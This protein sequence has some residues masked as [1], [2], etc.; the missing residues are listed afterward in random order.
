[1][2]DTEPTRVRAS[3]VRIGDEI[4]LG[5]T[6]D[7]RGIVAEITEHIAADADIRYGMRPGKPYLR[8]TVP[9]ADSTKHVYKKPESIMFVRRTPGA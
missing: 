8:F 7:L 3:Q 6:T 2:T 1:M 9:Y 5:G 4:S